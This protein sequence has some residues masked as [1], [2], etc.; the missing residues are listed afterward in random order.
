M[1]CG[2]PY[3]ILWV[4]I[5]VVADFLSIKLDGGGGLYAIS[6][7]GTGCSKIGI[8]FIYRMVFHS[9]T[10]FDNVLYCNNSPFM[11][12]AAVSLLMLFK[13]LQI[14]NRALKRAILTIAT[15]VMGVYLIHM[16]PGLANVFWNFVEQ[17]I[18]IDHFTVWI[19]YFVIIIAIFL[20][21]SMIELLRIKAVY[22][23][24]DKLRKAISVR[25]KR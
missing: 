14:E 22:F 8:A 3:C 19:F 7:I 11:L 20:F 16:H 1:L 10:G 21:C 18:N 17:N 24:K 25:V 5:S 9:T 4:L 23:A 15:T 13:D 2:L 6:I 12:L